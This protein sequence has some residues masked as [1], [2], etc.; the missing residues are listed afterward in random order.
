MS[1]SV[2]DRLV[3]VIEKTQNISADRIR[4]DSTFE[5]LGLDSF[6]GVNLLFALEEEFNITF[7]DNIEF[8]KTLRDVEN[9]IKEIL[10]N[11]AGSLS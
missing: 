1:L 10:L 3:H 4:Q 9:G 8:T 6:D 7:P 11:E 2:Y 5:E